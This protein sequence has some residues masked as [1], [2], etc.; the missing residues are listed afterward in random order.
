MGPPSKGR[1]LQH[2]P[3]WQA[4]SFFPQTTGFQLRGQETV[5]HATHTL[6]SPARREITLLD[7]TL[8][9]A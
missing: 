1:E 9:S 8:L 5:P 4:G 7:E 6:S 3:R 2:P